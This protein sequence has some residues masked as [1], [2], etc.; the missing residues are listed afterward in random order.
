MSNNLRTNVSAITLCLIAMQL[1][2]PTVAMARQDGGGTLPKREKLANETKTVDD[3]TSSSSSSSGGCASNY[4]RSC[5]TQT[6][7]TPENPGVTQ[8]CTYNCSGSC[9]CPDCH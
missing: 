7:R 1:G 9:V 2:T 8:V 6:C 4:G 3:G 5:S